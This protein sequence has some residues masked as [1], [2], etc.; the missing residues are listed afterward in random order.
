MSHGRRFLCPTDLDSPPWTLDRAEAHHVRKVLRLRSGDR[1]TL[2]DG[3]GGTV[4]AEL[5]FQSKGEVTA[6]PAGEPIRLPP[7]PVRPHLLL[8]APQLP[9]ADSVVEHA[10][11]LGVWEMVILRTG[12]SQVSEAALTKRLPRLNQLVITAAKQSGNPYFPEVRIAETL[13]GALRGLPKRGWLLRQDAP[14]LSPVRTRSTT[15]ADFTLAVGP[16]GDFTDEELL[17]LEAGDLRPASLAPHTLR[18]GTAALA[19]LS[20]F[21]LQIQSLE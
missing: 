14:P 9:Q 18:V 2:M 15:E 1:V 21:A 12:R 3:K 7:P 4:E 5:A 13:E 8:G 11:E 16:E 10:V 6:L 17:L 20:A 19:A